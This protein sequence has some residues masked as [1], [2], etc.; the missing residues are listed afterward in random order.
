MQKRSEKKAC[1]ELSPII[2]GGVVDSGAM[3]TNIQQIIQDS[4]KN[5]IP[6]IMR[7][8]QKQLEVSI[9]DIVK[10]SILSIQKEN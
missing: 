5:A 7:E 4:L 10:K 9:T 8:I 3:D 1:A 6:G 2:E